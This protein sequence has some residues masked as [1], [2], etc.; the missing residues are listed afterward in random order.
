MGQDPEGFVICPAHKARR[1]GWRSVPYTAT[2]MAVPGQ[3]G[4]TELEHERFVLHGVV[5]GELG[6]TKT[7]FFKAMDEVAKNQEVEA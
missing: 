7:E 4:W 6:M 2:T 1:Y 3:G 5:P